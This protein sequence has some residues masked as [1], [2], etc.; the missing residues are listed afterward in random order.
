MWR[1]ALVRQDLEVGD[2]SLIGMGAVVTRSVPPGEV[3]I[4][5]P[6]RRLRQLDVPADVR[7]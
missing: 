4:G 6:A 7:S 2:W 1:S 3:W 5:M